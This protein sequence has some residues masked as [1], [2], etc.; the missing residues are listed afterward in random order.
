V[1]VG[2]KQR[3][4]RVVVRGTLE[5]TDVLTDLTCNWVPYSS[6]GHVHEGFLHA[7]EWLLGDVSDILAAALKEHSG[8]VPISFLLFLLFTH[9]HCFLARQ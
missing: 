6:G 3:A 9:M 4:V 7:A 1:A 5:F 8:F 2:A